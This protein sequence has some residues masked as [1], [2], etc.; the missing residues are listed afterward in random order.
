MSEQAVLRAKF[1]VYSVKKVCDGN[2]DVTQEEVQLSAV[3]GADGSANKQWSQWTPSGSLTMS[4]SN[5]AAFDKLR[6]GQ[7]F[8]V[9]LILTDKDSL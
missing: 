6:P 3:Y 9:D 7:F 5:K 4:I 8:F 2:G 1:S